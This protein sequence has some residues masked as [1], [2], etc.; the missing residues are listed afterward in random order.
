MRTHI[1]V[2]PATVIRVVDG[3]TVKLLLDAGL[4]TYIK[5]SCRLLGVDTEELSSTDPVRHARAVE[6]KLFLET[7]LPVDSF[8]MFHSHQLDKYGRPLGRLVLADGRDVN[9]LLIPFAKVT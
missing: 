1:W 6:T 8:C 3:D 7:L 4:R 5:A 2:Y 9:T